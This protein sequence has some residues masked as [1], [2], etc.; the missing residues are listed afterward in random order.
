MC[1]GIQVAIAVLFVLSRT[2]V[3]QAYGGFPT[4][5]GI[6]ALAA[7]SISGTILVYRSPGVTRVEATELQALMTECV[8]KYRDSIPALP[9]VELAILDS[10]AWIRV[11]A[12]PYGLPNHNPAASP[13]VV[14]VPA[15]AAKLFP[16]P[17][18][19]DQ[20]D[21]FFHLV[22]LHE[23][24][25]VLMFAAIGVDRGAPW[26]EKHFPYWYLEFTATYIGLSCL[27]GR[28][29]DARLLRGSEDSLRAMPLP[30]F[31][32]L[33]EFS[34]V[35]TMEAPGRVPYVSTPR[36]AAHFAWYQGL[37]DEAAGRTQQRLGLGLVPLLRAQWARNGPVTTADIV[38]D[39]SQSDSGF[40][41]WLQ[42]F[43]A[44]P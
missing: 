9:R 13:V 38:R 7:D 20:P 25:H 6:Q 21:R 39:L 19:T 4:P 16:T 14:L 23:L 12:L 33:D 44:I 17:I 32:R 31:T 34:K 28:P 5:Q 27:S 8:T 11:T 22:A 43:G 3:G 37:M 15:T 42:G 2:A 18:R 1:T 40:I 26:D 35:L 29:A 36:G 30:S 24:G 41:S 10:A